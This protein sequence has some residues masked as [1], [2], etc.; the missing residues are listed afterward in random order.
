MPR[1][2]AVLA[3]LIAAGVGAQQAPPT[4]PPAGP[5]AISQP[6]PP[7][8][9]QP[10]QPK[11]SAHP[12]TPPVGLLTPIP[13]HGGLPPIYDKMYDLT[14]EEI[15][16]RGQVRQYA[17]QI[18]LIRHQHFGD[19]R[20]RAVRDQGIEMLSEFTD[21]AAFH[22]MI[23]ELKRELDDVRLAML[24]HFARHGEG[25]QTALAWMAIYDDNPAMRNEASK[26]MV[27]PPC[28]GVLAILDGAL[29]SPRHDVASLAAGLASSLNAVQ[30]IPL[31]IFAQ[32]ATET[33]QDQGDLAWIAIQT[34]HA[35]VQ[36][37]VPVV[38]DNSG[39]FQPIIGTFSDGSV[40][41][42][43]DAVVII[44]RTFVHESLVN[45]TTRDWGQPT[46]RL[47]Y[48]IK[49]WWEWYDTKYVPFKREQAEH[50]RLAAEP[51]GK[52]VAP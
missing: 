2:A 40:L 20:V 3:F 10:A 45:L 4:A 29:R 50:A 13:E 36:G 22:P 32:A 43:V 21:P 52:P 8:A 26:R 5:P 34:Q 38:G 12:R 46:D 23:E 14:A 19:I 44:Y 30:T 9:T 1:L 51:P 11:P 39:A 47:S 41:R 17:K 15:R 24:D 33:N 49:A 35:Y 7:P 48:N 27:A 28:N 25:G 42:V 31:L 16:H 18:R 37:L 6:A